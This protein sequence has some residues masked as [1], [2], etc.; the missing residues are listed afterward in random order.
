MHLRRALAQTYFVGYTFLAVCCHNSKCD[1]PGGEIQ[2]FGT[3]CNGE[4]TIRV[5]QV[6]GRLMFSVLD[7]DSNIIIQQNR[8]MSVYQHW[9]LFLDSSKNFWVFSSDIGHSVWEKDHK[10]GRYWERCFSRPLTRTDVPQEI[11]DSRFVRFLN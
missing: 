7:A 11:Y 9:G 5:A 3:Y 6:N 1:W 8:N 4:L 10:T 2:D